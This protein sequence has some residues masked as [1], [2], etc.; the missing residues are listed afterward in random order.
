MQGMTP[1]LVPIAVSVAFVLACGGVSVEPRSHLEAVCKQTGPVDIRAPLAQTDLAAKPLRLAVTITL[2]DS[3]HLVNWHRF[4]SRASL[5]DVLR[6]ELETQAVLAERLGEGADPRVLLIAAQDTPAGLVRDVVQAAHE[7]GVGNLDIA[8]AS[9]EPYAP[10]PY[11]D[12]DYA[13]ELQARLSAV[14]PES[15]AV[16]LA[17][18]LE[19]LLTACPDG[20]SA[21]AAVAMASPDTKCEMFAA[22]LGEA[23]PGCVLTNGDK[24]VTAVQVAT[25]PTA[26]TQPTYISVTPTPD[27]AAVAFR[28]GETWSDVA[29][30]LV[31][32]DGTPVWLP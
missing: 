5:T 12:P 10:V 22:G 11:P 4:D 29:G 24:V 18:E 31:A 23:L 19:G 1:R 16:E 9:N 20:Q 13:A 3:E 14:S 28:P 26:P 30:R 27:G 17:Q 15:R 2:H 7:V 32:H 6:E 25:E 8:L 21:F